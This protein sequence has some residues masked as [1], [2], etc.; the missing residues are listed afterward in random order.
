MGK[1]PLFFFWLRTLLLGILCRCPKCGKGNIF[2]GLFHVHSQCPACQV[3]LQPYVGDSAGVIGLGY[4]VFVV[5]SILLAVAVGY[6]W[7]AP[8]LAVFATFALSSTGLLLLFYRNMKSSWIAI[9][10]LMTGLRKNL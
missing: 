5:P 6:Y 9:V 2:R 4:C 3:T 8:P 7:K 10:Y 1:T